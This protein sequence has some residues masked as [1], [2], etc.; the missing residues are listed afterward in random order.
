MGKNDKHTG[1]NTQ[2]EL[3]KVLAQEHLKGN[4]EAQRI[5]AMLTGKNSK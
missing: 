3:A 1:T 4:S 5:L 2:T